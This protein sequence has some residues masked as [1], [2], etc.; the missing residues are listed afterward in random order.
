[1]T[2][3]ERI[4]I[5]LGKRNRTQAWLAEQ[6]GLVQSAISKAIIGKRRLY[7]DQ[8]EAIAKALDMP[9]EEMLGLGIDRASEQEM[10]VVRF[11]RRLNLTPDEAIFKLQ[12]KPDIVIQG[13]NKIPAGG[14]LPPD[15]QPKHPQSQMPKKH[16]G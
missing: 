14:S 6:V 13:G 1:M 5:A 9:M 7:F 10:I 16:S 12:I 4:N 15:L 2:I 3:G 8:V 11:M